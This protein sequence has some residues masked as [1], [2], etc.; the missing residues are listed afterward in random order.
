[1]NDADFSDV[2]RAA[3]VL[4]RYDR[5]WAVCGGWAIDLHL[6]R[7]TRPHKDVDFAMLRKD[8]LVVQDHL[9]SKGWALQKAVDGHL[10]P[11]RAGEWIDLPVHTIWCKNVQAN[12]D[13]IEILFNETDG[14]D[15]LFR[16]DFSITLPLEKMILSSASGAPILAPAIVL[17]YKSAKPEDPYAATDFKNI[18]PELAPDTRDWLAA[19]LRKLH[20]NHIWLKSLS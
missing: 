17:L 16:R 6:N 9:L 20:P 10:I 13:F 4:A 3:K 15:F 5:P 14:V 19:A 12:P 1:M 2:I 7:V 11:W 18:L 8:Q